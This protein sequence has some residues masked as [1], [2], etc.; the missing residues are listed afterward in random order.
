[1]A[2]A[3][4]N[5]N[6]PP[7]LSF[8]SILTGSLPCNATLRRTWKATDACG[9]MSTCVQSISIRDTVPPSIVC[10]P[11]STVFTLP[12]KC[13]YSGPIP[14]PT[15]TDN[16]PPPPTIVCQWFNGTNFVP[17]TPATQ[18]PKGVHTIR[19]YAEDRCGNRS[20]TCSYTLTV[21]DNEP[22]VITCPPNLI[23]QGQIDATGQCKATVQN[24]GAIANDNCP[25]WSVSWTM[26]GA[27]TGSG[28]GNASGTMF[29]AGV[30]TVTYT[31]TDMAGNSVACSFTVTVVCD[32]PPFR[33]LC[34]QA[35]VT[36]FS[37]FNNPVNPSSGV[38]LNGPVAAVYDVR[39]HAAAPTGTWW[40]TVNKIMHPNWTAANLG[41]VF[42]IAIA[43]NQEIFVTASTVY[44]CSQSAYPNPFG[45]AGGGGVYRLNPLTGAVQ[46]FVQTGPFV[47]GGNA[48]PNTGSGLGNICHDPTN[49]Q[50]F[51][52]NMSDGMIYRVQNTPAGFGIVLDRF[53]PF[54][55]TNPPAS[56]QGANPN[57]VALGERTWGVAYYNGRVYF[58]RWREDI[59]RRSTSAANEIWSIGLSGTGGF[60]SSNN[61][62]GTFWGGETMAVNMA[63][64]PY[65]LPGVAFSNPISDIEFS[66]TGKML[67]AERTM[68][69]DCG[70]A[71]TLNQW[72]NWAHSSRVLEFQQI[73][74]TWQLT[75]GHT[76]PISASNT[77]LKFQ[78]GDNAQANSAG[79]VD[80]G[81]ES[82]INL[83][84]VPPA[85]CDSIVWGT[86]DNLH[87]P[88]SPI[89]WVYGMQGIRSSGQD[90]NPPLPHDHQAS[91]L[92]DFDN[93]V[94]THD[95]ILIGDVDVLKCG[96][97]PTE[98][99]PPCDSL[100]VVK[101]P[102]TPDPGL[103]V[104]SC[105]WSV[106]L[107]VHH[108]PVGYIEAEIIT[109]G[110]TFSNASTSSNFTFIPLTTPTLLTIK[111]NPFQAIPQGVYPNA[112]QFCLNNIT[113]TSQV[114]QVVVF[115]WYVKGPNDVPY[116]ACTDTCYF[117]CRPPVMSRDTCLAIKNDTIICDPNNP[118][119]FTY[120]FQVQNLSNF[121][122]NQVI[123]SN[124]PAGF[125]F[126]PCPPPSILSTSTTI[127]LPNPALVPGIAPDSCSP[128]LCVKIV[129]SAPVLTPTLFTF[130]ASLSS[131]DTCCHAPEPFSVWLRP[132]CNPCERKSVV[133]RPRPPVDSCCHT[134]DI[135]NPCGGNYFTKLE[136]AL[137][138]PGVNFGS[139]YTGGS[140]PS[141]WS[142]PVS[143][144][145][146]IQWQHLSGYVPS[147]TL[148]GLINF[149]LDDINQP[150]EVPQ[151]V[152]LRWITQGANGRDSVA[153]TDTLRFDCPM[154]VDHGCVEVIEDRIRCVKDNAGN[155][156]Y[157]YTLTFLNTS[158]PPHF[159]TELIFTQI[160]G[161]PV[162]VFPNPVNFF[163]PGL[164][165]NGIQTITTDIYPL[166]GPLPVGTKLVFAIRL[167]DAISGDNWCCFEA[168]T[169]CIFIPPCDSCLCAHDP[170][171]LTQGGLAYTL[172]CNSRGPLT[173]LNC[174]ATNITLSGF[175]GCKDAQTDELCDET[176]VQ[177]E[178][179]RPNNLPS[180][181]GTTT[182]YSTLTFPASAVSTPGQY[183][184]TRWT[185]CPGTTDTCV[186]RV[187]W[188]QPSCD[189]C[190]ADFEAF[191][192]RVEN[193]V[194][195]SLQ[196]NQCKVTLN[197]GTLPNCDYL[198]WV[199][200]G[201]GSPIQYGT[202]GSNAMLM[203]TYSGS[204]TY[205]ISYLAIEI[206]P[207]T[208]LICFE[209]IL[210][211]TIQLQCGIT[212][213]CGG[214]SNLFVRD[215]KPGGINIPVTCNNNTPVVLP[216][217]PGQGYY[218]TGAFHCAGASC[219]PTHQINWTLSGPG[220]S[221]SG[222]FIDNDPFFGI[223]LLPSYFNQPGLYTLVLSGNCGSDICRCIIRFVVDCPPLCPCTPQ[224]IQ[225]LAAAVSQGFAVSTS[226]T[227]CKACFSPLALSDCEQVR[228]H[229]N[230]ITSPSIGQT[231]GNQTFCHTFSGSGTYTIIMVVTRLKPDGSLCEVFTYSKV[232]HLNCL[233]VVSECLGSL[234]PNA[235]F[236][237]NPV[238][239]SLRSGSG[240]A[241][242]W[243]IVEHSGDPHELYLLEY[244]SSQDGWV[245][246]PTGTYT[247]AGILGTVEPLCLARNDTGTVTLRLRTPGDPIP[248]VSVKMG[249]KPPGGAATIVLYTGNNSVWPNC[250]GGGCYTLANLEDLFPFDDD[251]WY[252]LQIPYDLRRWAASDSC[253][254]GRGVPA[255]LAVYMSYPLSMD[256]GLTDL[257]GFLI[258]DICLRGQVVGVREAPLPKPLRLYPNPTAGSVTV[259]WPAPSTGPALLRITSP[260]G[261]V[262]QQQPAEAGTRWHELDLRALPAG[263]YF[264]EVWSEGRIAGI[265]RIVRQ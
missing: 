162:A 146:L 200:W 154:I 10:P 209:K 194:S 45:P 140:S 129:S 120:F 252:D 13:Y 23:V 106:D 193:A 88:T 147:G 181:F 21:V 125:A 97:P 231:W 178:L 86:G 39:N 223:H 130:Q 94:Q 98:P 174:P 42:G 62:G 190:C 253:A 114:P 80:Y 20:L 116:L 46:T 131:V 123:L 100:W 36:C 83:G 220:G 184:L 251:S 237:V 239:G 127:A 5:C 18:F 163:P 229:I 150:S 185:I 55:Q 104:D 107:H 24:I 197:V 64:Y 259:E 191:C 113:N 256:Q 264:V 43:P 19:C 128:M 7:T 73:G 76:T 205:V 226:N 224:I 50:F 243:R 74:S 117:E 167:R 41:Q 121:T 176:V 179:T 4:D 44:T 137:L 142:N 79:G 40:N 84:T 261:Q 69:A 3:T 82:F 16:C 211:D 212:C 68:S 145:N 225:N 218:L 58:S 77:N 152:V 135:I 70:G 159:A 189:T 96:C 6:P 8:T 192:Q 158:T 102:L 30:T 81:Y 242:G 234:L 173:V 90:N 110:V 112:L 215:K 1:M 199:D 171:L 183:C 72:N 254:G 2:T 91:I 49:N 262:L 29:M 155:V 141:T 59:G 258:D 119:E 180:L 22:P 172:P 56:G 235:G 101:H 32:Q 250:Q 165:W 47:P 144:A 228:W 63:S 169:L 78:I 195:L 175:L 99:P 207:A 67:I 12:G 206:N 15:A 213:S 255:R 260:T 14:Q 240:F 53:D 60:A 93:D 85:P 28:S 221:H 92:I 233:N 133:V 95:K 109:P 51:V 160:G 26:T 124:P 11:N 57:F 48:I 201:D 198:E 156:H 139:H 9:N 148:N 105:C 170:V 168:D 164:P 136:L 263:L 38:N 27:T 246:V 238:A 111:H 216:C 71:F 103:P 227:Q 188:L 75:P 186:C 222:S 232:I 118:N 182:N 257:P 138:T 132:C 126:R 214:F 230:S 37:G 52:T 151:V 219:P 157:Q 115:R 87:P 248:G 217:R 54:G 249:R 89:T 34:G 122:A 203:H 31:V 134:L 149:C 143:T 187:C 35:A 204:G 241:P 166:S 236:N 196:P 247:G 177:W 25:M 65:P 208:G 244:G 61:A 17:I 66:H 33:R 265:G 245:M 153:C 202:F 210:R 161:P 108:G